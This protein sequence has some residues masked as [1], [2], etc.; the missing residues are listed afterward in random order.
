MWKR[1]ALAALMIGGT[2]MAVLTQ[3]TPAFDVVSIK[4]NRSG[5]PASTSNSNPRI[6]YMMNNG[7]VLNMIRQAY[8]SQNLEIA[9]APDWVRTERY[10]VVAKPSGTPT[11][12]EFR[13]MMRAMLA[14]RFRLQAH[15]EDREQPV[16]RLVLARSDGRLGDQ[17]RH[18]TLDCDAIRAANIRGEPIAGIT[19]SNDAP[20][21]GTRSNGSLFQA[22]GI[23]M[24]DFAA[25]LS[26]VAGRNVID[27]T[28]LP[29][30]YEFTLRFSAQP[31][32][33]GT[34]GDDAPSLFT[35]VE[36]QLGLKLEPS[37]APLQT[38]V[39]DHIER[40]TDN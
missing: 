25:Y 8:P 2:T 12:D 19:V 28:G 30:R 32:P 29:N 22:G 4:P 7:V 35:A 23:A 36:E 9:G 39:I 33:G 14:D 15:Y 31:S 3:T 34:N 11:S 40:P 38:L 18:S 5:L 27:A 24:R 37:R 10:D 21:C 16:Y 6:G 20:P 13:L 26:L 1:L 17:I